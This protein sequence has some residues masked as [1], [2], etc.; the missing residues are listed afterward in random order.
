MALSHQCNIQQV[1]SKFIHK[2]IARLQFKDIVRARVSV[3]Y[4]I[5]ASLKEL[6][7]V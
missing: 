5:T 4:S 7:A 6:D 3:K 1:K 2:V